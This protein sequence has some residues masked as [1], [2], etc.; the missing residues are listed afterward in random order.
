MA[1]VLGWRV[2]T[3]HLQGISQDAEWFIATISCNESLRSTFIACDHP[4]GVFLMADEEFTCSAECPYDKC[5]VETRWED[6]EE[7]S[8]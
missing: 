8:E 7:D 3:E 1:E 4:L 2:A 6:E 5:V